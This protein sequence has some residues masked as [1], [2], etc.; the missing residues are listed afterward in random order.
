[1]PDNECEISK[2]FVAKYGNRLDDGQDI[3]R[4]AK[5]EERTNENSKTIEKINETLDNLFSRINESERTILD[6]LERS[7]NN[8]QITAPLIL[9]CIGVIISLAL[10]GGMLIN[11][12]M[13]PLRI[14]IDHNAKA[15]TEHIIL[16]GH[17]DA[18]ERHAR[19]Q[20]WDTNI[21]RRILK[22]ETK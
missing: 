17:P 20:M 19:Q 9:S 13:D 7:Q 8:R 12:A 11:G 22:L 1:M 21:E 10:V 14:N 2:A 5:L 18:L 15:I 6:K 4:L 3:A 16:Q